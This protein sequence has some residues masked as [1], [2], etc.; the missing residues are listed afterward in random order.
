MQRAF[1]CSDDSY[2]GKSY[3][4]RRGWV[5]SLLF[6]LAAVFAID[7]AAFSVMSNHLHLGLRVDIDS[8][9]HWTDRKGL[10]QWHNYWEH[11]EKRRHFAK[12]CQH[13]QCN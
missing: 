13:F 10:E 5:K 11:L 2:S 7:V 6:E 1:L 9:N 8:A 12:C 4:Y 3:D